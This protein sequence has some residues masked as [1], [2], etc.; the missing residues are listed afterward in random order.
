MDGVLCCRKIVAWKMITNI[1]LVLRAAHQVVKGEQKR[2]KQ[3]E[4]IRKAKA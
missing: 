1:K 4:E 2:K 3:E